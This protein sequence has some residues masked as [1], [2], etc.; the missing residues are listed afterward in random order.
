MAKGA[1]PG[2]VG[3]LSKTRGAKAD[4]PA[5]ER[6][7]SISFDAL[8]KLCPKL[9]GWLKEI[10][11]WACAGNSALIT[12]LS[13]DKGWRVNLYTAEH[14]YSI[15]AIPCRRDKRRGYLG[16][17]VGSRRARAGEDWTRGNDLADGKFTDKTWRKIK[18]D[19]LA[20]ELVPLQMS[21]GTPA[22]IIK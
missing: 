11:R 2:L 5:P 1:I 12:D 3:R 13:Y 10:D 4:K 16:C 18:D 17:T 15:V 6:V 19:M 8:K 22:G 21:P 9:H 14:A 20:Y 7:K